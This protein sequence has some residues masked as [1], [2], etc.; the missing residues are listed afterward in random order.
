MYARLEAL[1]RQ[2][3]AAERAEQLRHDQVLARLVGERRRRVAH[4]RQ[5]DE[6]L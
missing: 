4:V 6:Y 1:G 5:T 2:L 3:V